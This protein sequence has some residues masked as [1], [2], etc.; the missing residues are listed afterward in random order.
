MSSSSR[1][2]SNTDWIAAALEETFNLP[3][4]QFSAQPPTNP[5]SLAR[6]KFAHQDLRRYANEAILPKMDI[7][8]SVPPL[9]PPGHRGHLN[10]LLIESEMYRELDTLYAIDDFEK[11]A[12]EFAMLNLPAIRKGDSD[13]DHEKGGGIVVP[14]PGF[15]IS[16]FVPIGKSSDITRVLR[17]V[18]ECPL[19]TVSHMMHLVYPQTVDYTLQPGSDEDG[20]RE[21][22]RWAMWSR[23]ES[24]ITEAQDTWS[25]SVL[26]FVQPPWILTPADFEAFVN[27]RTFPPFSAR[28]P[29]KSTERLWGKIWD[30][31]A[32]KRSH[33]FV[34][35]TYWGWVFGAFSPGRSRAFTSEII[36]FD[37]KGPTVIQCLF[38]WFTCAIAGLV[39]PHGAWAVPEV[40]GERQNHN[41]LRPCT[42]RSICR[43]RKRLKERDALLALALK[44]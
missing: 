10:R 40:S 39:H 14:A 11:T 16:S 29:L 33:W 41:V 21:I 3:F 13:I 12:Q 7:S 23:D 37:L 28:K 36:P 38:F 25:E 15:Q 24:T 27:L 17:W 8:S 1:P 20:D 4:R 35:T 2:R 42:Y 31:C 6:K 30:V 19:A 32:Q 43:K 34:L 44:P 22:F 5:F 26:V 18:I 9:P